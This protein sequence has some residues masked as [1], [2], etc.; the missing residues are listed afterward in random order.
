MANIKSQEKRILTNEKSRLAN[1]SFKSSVKTAIKKALVAKKA[2]SAD[3][4]KLVNE[5]VS[6][7]DKGVTK[8]IFKANKAARE[9]SRL[10]SA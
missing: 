10:M 3:K 6:L 7:V 5:A 9:K 4:D 1:K 8:G 2:N